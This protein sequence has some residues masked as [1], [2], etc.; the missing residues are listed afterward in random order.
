M[1]ILKV[2]EW[3]EKKNT[4]KIKFI[5]EGFIQKIPIRTGRI[6]KEAALETLQTSFRINKSNEQ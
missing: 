3:L 6:Y 1:E 4:S 5:L 2:K